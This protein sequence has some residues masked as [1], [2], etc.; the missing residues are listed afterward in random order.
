M[1][2]AASD[3]AAEGQVGYT[4]FACIGAGF[5][6]IG[7]GATLKRRYGISDVRLFERESDL[8]G[9]WWIN[10]YPGQRAF[11]MSPDLNEVRTKLT[12]PR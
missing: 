10:Q 6:G 1:P 2:T 11:I 7:L 5:S 8:G 12:S 3:V 4:Q 9:T